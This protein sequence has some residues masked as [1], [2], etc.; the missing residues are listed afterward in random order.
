MKKLTFA[1]FGILL[2]GCSGTPYQHLWV[3]GGYSEEALRPGKWAVTFLSNIAS[4][5]GYAAEAALYRSA[6]LADSHGFNYFKVVNSNIRT[7]QHAVGSAGGSFCCV[8]AGETAV[9]TVVGMTASDTQA[10]CETPNVEICV[11]FE[12]KKVLAEYGPS[13]HAKTLRGR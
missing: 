12:T 9:L 6:E 11:V 8:S 2:A 3:G 1:L 7:T 13:V 5:R 10:P 4:P